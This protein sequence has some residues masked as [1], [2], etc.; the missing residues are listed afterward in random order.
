[1]RTGGHFIGCVTRSVTALSIII[2]IVFGIGAAA[3]TD[4]ETTAAN[5]GNAETRQID[6]GEYRGESGDG[7]IF[8]DVSP[9]NPYYHDIM[10]L[11]DN[12]YIN[13]SGND[14]FRPDDYITPAEALTILERLYGDPAILPKA[15]EEWCSPLYSYKAKWFDPV[16]TRGEYVDSF[17]SLDSA[18]SWI[19][20]ILKMPLLPRHIYAYPDAA[21]D[22]RS[23]AL[24]SMLIYGNPAPGYMNK[25][26][27]ERITRGEFCNLVVWAGDIVGVIPEP[28]FNLPVEMSVVTDGYETEYMASINSLF[29]QDTLLLVP[30]AILQSFV[31][32]GYE[33]KVMPRDAYIE[34]VESRY[35]PTYA[36]STSG[37]YIHAADGRQGE[38]V[39][40]STSPETILHEM[41]HYV[42]LNILTAWSDVERLY[43]DEYELAGVSGC[44][45][46]DYCKKN[47]KEF[48]AESF[49]AYIKMP[50]LLAERAPSTYSLIDGI[51]AWDKSP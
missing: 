10:Y 15:W 4:I 45:M 50:E 40:N 19:L 24:W 17:V 41:G 51:G 46:S 32:N 33:I 29:V 3:L 36:N 48:F 47:V 11:A 39:V 13:G 31:D 2:A 43:E 30:E 25:P 18:S 49:V 35:G 23:E 1:M 34:Y 26:G 12:G 37:L 9:T 38:I 42:F 44:F 8:L 28:H 20:A 21:T 5:A 6:N 22:T 27:Y 14:R 16:E 7:R